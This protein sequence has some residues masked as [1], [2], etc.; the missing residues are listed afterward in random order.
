M[1]AIKKI[2]SFLY[3][4]AGLRFVARLVRFMFRLY[5]DFIDRVLMHR[6]AFG[7]FILVG[8]VSVIGSWVCW[9]LDWTIPY[10]MLFFIF[11]FIAFSF[12]VGLIRKAHEYIT[13]DEDVNEYLSSLWK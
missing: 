1:N 6:D 10:N 12:I 11:E 7:F 8:C 5:M 3:T 9:S 4:I 13:T 2:I